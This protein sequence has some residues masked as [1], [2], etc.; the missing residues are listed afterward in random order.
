V[1]FDNW[2]ASQKQGIKDKMFGGQVQDW[3][4]DTLSASV[5]PKHKIMGKTIDLC[6]PEKIASEKLRQLVGAIRNALNPPPTQT[7]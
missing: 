5:P 7:P 6:P 3:L 1:P 4:A 2:L